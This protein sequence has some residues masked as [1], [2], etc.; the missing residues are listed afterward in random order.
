MDDVLKTQV[1]DILK[2]VDQYRKISFLDNSYF[3]YYKLGKE[4]WES[5]KGIEAHGHC[6]IQ[7]ADQDLRTRN[8]I[9]CPGARPGEGNVICDT[10]PISSETKPDGVQRKSQSISYFISG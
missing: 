3:I 4:N 2:Q 5:L 10:R 7:S 8:A 6:V 9:T 1:L